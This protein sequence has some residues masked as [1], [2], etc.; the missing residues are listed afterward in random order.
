MFD[1]IKRML[2]VIIEEDSVFKMLFRLILI[3]CNV[4]RSW[5]VLNVYG[6]IFILI[7]IFV[8]S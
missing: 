8:I 6:R 4:L 3:I 2:M 1:I 5:S 7:V